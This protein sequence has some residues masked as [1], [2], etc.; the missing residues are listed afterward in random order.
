[1]S[2]RKEEWRGNPAAAGRTGGFAPG[3]RENAAAVGRSAGFAPGTRGKA[4]AVGRKAGFA[5]WRREAQRPGVERPVLQMDG[6]EMPD[7]E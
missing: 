6:G 1:M 2:G 4:A 7:S 3:R 5:H